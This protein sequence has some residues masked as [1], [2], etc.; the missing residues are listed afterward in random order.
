MQANNPR[1]VWR[2]IALDWFPKRHD[3]IAA[4][5][6]NAIGMLKSMFAHGKNYRKWKAGMLR[7]QTSEI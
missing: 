5:R 3:K 2:K 4:V 1:E 6:Q 7:N